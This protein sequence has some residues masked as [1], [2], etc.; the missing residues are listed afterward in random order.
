MRLAYSVEQAATALSISRR[1]V[2]RHL[3]GGRLVAVKDGNRT[4]IPRRELL[5]FLRSLPAYE[6][7]GAA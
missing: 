2:Y 3:K 4:L 1:Q 5:R 7:R 6:R